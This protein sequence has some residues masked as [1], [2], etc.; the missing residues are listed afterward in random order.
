LGCDHAQGYLYAKPMAASQ[1]PD[2]LSRWSAMLVK[3]RHEKNVKL[4]GI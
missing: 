2:L 3:P 4:L 1:I